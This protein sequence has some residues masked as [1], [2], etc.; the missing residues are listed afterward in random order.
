MDDAERE[1]RNRVAD[2]IELIADGMKA[3]ADNLGMD[4]SPRIAG[5]INGLKMAACI[6]RD[7]HPKEEGDDDHRRE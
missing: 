3:M 1:L 2:Q 6:V 5:T 7:N 4:I